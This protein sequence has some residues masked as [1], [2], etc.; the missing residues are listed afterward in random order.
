[1]VFFTLL[2]SINIHKTKAMHTKDKY[3]CLLMVVV[4]ETGDVGLEDIKDD[5]E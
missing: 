5:R 2:Y 4:G 1:M 3:H